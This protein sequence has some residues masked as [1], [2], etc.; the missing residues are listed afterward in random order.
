MTLLLLSGLNRKVADATSS[1][2]REKNNLGHRT[3]DQL[4]EITLKTLKEQ[5][6][7][8]GSLLSTLHLATT[9]R[10]MLLIKQHG[11]IRAEFHATFLILLAKHILEGCRRWRNPWLWSVN[12]GMRNA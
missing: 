12:V 11:R 6:Y 1:N 5:A 2:E 10:R 8:A 9:A 4:L 3:R 7:G